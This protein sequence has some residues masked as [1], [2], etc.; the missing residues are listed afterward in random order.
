MTVDLTHVTFPGSAGL[1]VLVDAQDDAQQMGVQP[2]S[3]GVDGNRVVPRARR[4]NRLAE[5]FDIG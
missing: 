2:S 5:L 1:G 4:P 3:T